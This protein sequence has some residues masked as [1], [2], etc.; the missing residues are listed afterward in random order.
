M[1]PST[2][3]L[4]ETNLYLITPNINNVV[5]VRDSNSIDEKFI[6]HEYYTLNTAFLENEQLGERRVN[7]F[8]TIVA[9]VLTA[10]GATLSLFFGIG[11]GMMGSVSINFE[12]FI[13]GFLLISV[14]ATFFLLLFGQ[15]TLLRLLHRDRI[16]DEYKDKIA[17]IRSYFAE[18]DSDYEIV[19]FMAFNPYKRVNQRIWK[20][21][22]SFGKGGLTKTVILLNSMLLFMLVMIACGLFVLQYMTNN[23]TSL[24]KEKQWLIIVIGFLSGVAV[25]LAYWIL[26]TAAIRKSHSSVQGNKELEA[27]FIIE[28][29]N[30]KSTYEQLRKIDKIKHYRIL[31]GYHEHICDRY[32]DTEQN[33]LA[34]KQCSLRIRS[35][36]NDVLVTLKGKTI[37]SDNISIRSEIEEPLNDKAIR[38]INDSLN[39][40]GILNV[41]LSYNKKRNSICLTGWKCIQHR[42][43][44]RIRRPVT[45]GSPDSPIIAELDLDSVFYYMDGADPRQY[46][47]HY[48]NVEIES[49]LKNHTEDLN[50]LVLAFVDLNIGIRKWNK[51][52]LEMGKLFDKL[53]REEMIE[54][55]FLDGDLK[56][57]SYKI[58]EGFTGY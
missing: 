34:A 16:T 1:L 38:K 9:A 53:Y 3:R 32:Y 7:L 51:S 20:K 14:F 13:W 46:I 6:L 33:E 23:P 36:S 21:T 52:K 4:T 49:I 40:F 45:Y 2:F 28:R 58:L 57:S 22:F 55:L 35:S 50:Y 15:V 29:D 18:K 41:A 43:I 5:I 27:T 8:T 47:T 12:S 39:K 10:L 11:D 30:P 31:K 48:Y 37:H 26:Q 19:N 25:F 24:E 54:D 44:L 42:D 17:K 56:A